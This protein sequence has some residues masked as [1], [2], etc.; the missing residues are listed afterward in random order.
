[1]TTGIFIIVSANHSANN[2]FKENYCFLKLMSNKRMGTKENNLQLPPQ[3]S[4]TNS[5]G[6]ESETEYS[7]FK[8]REKHHKEN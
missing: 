7:S 6:S 3:F 2:N 8:K 5:S 4:N 1:M